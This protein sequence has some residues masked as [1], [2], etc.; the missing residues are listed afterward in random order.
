MHMHTL[1][2]PP[3]QTTVPEVHQTSTESSNTDTPSHVPVQGT[4]HTNGQ[5]HTD[6]TNISYATSSGRVSCPLVRLDS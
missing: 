2:N 3:V 1:H 6:S 4:R 5:I